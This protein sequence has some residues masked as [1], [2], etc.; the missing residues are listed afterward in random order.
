MSGVKAWAEAV[1][2]ADGTHHRLGDRPLYNERFDEVLKFHAPGLAPARRGIA[3]WHIQIDGA[4]AYARRFLQTFGFYEGLAAA[5]S[6]DGWHHV[7]PDGSDAYA[8][9]HGWC[10]NFQGGRCTVRGPDGRYLH[11][12][13][14]GRPVCEHYW[15]Y[16]G[17]FRDG[18][19]VVAREDGRSTHIDQ[20][21]H[22]VHGRWF[23]DL[24]VFHKGFARARDE[25]GWMHVDGAGRPGYVRRF[26]SVEPFYNGQARV[27]DFDGAVEII[28]EAGCTRLT[29][30]PGLPGVEFGEGRL[31]AWRIGEVL[32]RGSHGAVYAS[33]DDAVIKSTS[34]L[35]AWS[36]EASLLDVLG[37]VGAP[38][39]LDAFTRAGTGYLVMGR[40]RGEP[41]GARN[42]TQARPIAE[43]VRVVR[44]LL[45][46]V[47]RLHASGWLHTDIHPENVLESGKDVVLLDLANAVHMDGA[48]RWSGEVHWGR[49][50]FVPPEQ[51][52]GFRVLDTSAD[53]YALAG[54]LVYLATGRGPFPVDVAGLRGRGWAAV[55]EA[56]RVARAQPV[57]GEVPA[58]L[59]S[60]LERGLDQDPG[61]R[62]S[63][64]DALR[65]ALEGLNE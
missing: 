59:R 6:D 62:Y 50:E 17:D 45:D 48:G 64:F 54:L 57:I 39:L 36:R 51:F 58:K 30:R 56:F 38:R 11:I 63:T 32:H 7:L 46:T 33:G 52:E 13:A 27:E 40:V 4:A 8:A 10:G 37:G 9:R 24:D 16:A 5:L 26:A 53:T 29:V 42:R 65:I 18:V 3:A 22:P 55:R 43:A 60:V 15:R 44:G 35:A 25:R 1:V 2:A 47:G 12:I 14:D 34:N 20:D 19:A 31:G 21:G 61:Q 28:D 41:L 23:V 49:W